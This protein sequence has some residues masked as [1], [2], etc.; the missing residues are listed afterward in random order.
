MR[1]PELKDG[2]PSVG[3]EIAAAGGWGQAW[4]WPG[5]CSATMLWGALA[6]C[7]GP[8]LLPA[9]S[10]GTPEVASALTLCHT[11]LSKWR[12]LKGPLG[13]PTSGAGGDMGGPCTASG[14]GAGTRGLLGTLWAGALGGGAR[15]GVGMLAG[16]AHCPPDGPR[17]LLLL[18]GRLPPDP[19]YGGC[20]PALLPDKL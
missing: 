15:S 14:S 19:G 11:S 2:G 4:A 17:F 10:Q 7:A 1:E 9:D 12:G 3:E 5:P 18:L 6:L 8:L 20:V 13:K 16:G